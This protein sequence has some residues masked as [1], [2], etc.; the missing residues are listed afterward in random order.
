MNTTSRI[1]LSPV[2]PLR[3]ARV[4]TAGSG[5]RLMLGLTAR[6][7]RRESIGVTPV[8]FPTREP[9]G[10]RCLATALDRLT[11]PLTRYHE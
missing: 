10:V 3:S 7:I 6:K 1:H 5:G 9:S 11:A 4:A 2:L 8:T